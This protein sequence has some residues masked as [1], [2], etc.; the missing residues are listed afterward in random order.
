MQQLSGGFFFGWRQKI[1][2]PRA[3]KIQ[4]YSWQPRKSGSSV[5]DRSKK[6]YEA[7]TFPS[8]LIALYDDKRLTLTIAVFINTLILHEEVLANLTVLNYNRY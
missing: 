6:F 3:K 8:S 2:A 7:S 5:D 4:V 1:F